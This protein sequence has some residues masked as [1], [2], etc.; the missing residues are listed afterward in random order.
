MPPTSVDPRPSPPEPPPF[1]DVPALLQLSRPQPGVNW[2]G[3][4][5]MACLATAVF[6][7]L[8]SSRQPAGGG[9]GPQSGAGL[10]LL[11]LSGVGIAGFVSA[12]RKHRRQF[13]V[14]ESVEEMVQLRRWEPAGML[15]DRFLSTPV[16]SPRLWARALVQLSAVLAR[17]HRFADAVTVDD[18]LLDVDGL[19]DEPTAYGVRAMRAMALL[20]DGSLLDADRAIGDLRRR[21]PGRESGPLALIEIY[22]DV[23]TGHPDEAVAI[24]AAKRDVL[25]RHLGHRVADAHALVARAYDQLGREAEAA[26]AYA[27]ATALAPAAEL[28][29]RYPEVGPVAAKYP[30]TPAPAEV[31]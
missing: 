19:L 2:V 27:R 9:A 15:L 6:L 4:V 28:L 12:V 31:A 22:R 21:G 7:A 8:S 13:G 26:A 23:Q 10:V 25:R 29:R 1:L 11:M 30:A 14:V 3:Y 17:H 5:A 24:F 20:R 16:R 18:F